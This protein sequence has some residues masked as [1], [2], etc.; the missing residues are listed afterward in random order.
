MTSA[1]PLN[2]L[3]VGSAGPRIAFVHGLFGQGR[4]WNQI[5]KSVAWPNG[6][7]ARALLIDL[8]DHGRSPWSEEFSYAA[9][10]D[11]VAA[12][13]RAAA[14]GEEW[15]LVGHS[16]GGKTS[17]L[18]A[19]QHPDLIARLCVVD[20]APKSYGDLHR[21]SAYIDGMQRLPLGEIATREEADD[22]FTAVEPDPGVRAFL[23]QNL[24]RDHDGWSWRANLDLIAADAARGEESRIADFPDTSGLAPYEGPVVWLVGAESRYVKD[25]DS[26]PMRAL[27]PQVRKVTVKGAGHWVH[28]DAPAVVIETLR[29]LL[30]TGGPHPTS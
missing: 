3:A 24:R 11:A 5:A 22:W 8:P 16:L 7:Q 13:L 28:T 15:T 4:N 18:A 6:T 21:F 25:D 20:I 29:H 1:G 10:A 12:T 30:R 9:Y 14:P 23:L 2:T 27:F 17:M 26:A 19:L